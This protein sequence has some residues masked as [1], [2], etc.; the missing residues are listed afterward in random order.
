[1]VPRLPQ[2]GEHIDDH[3]VHFSLKLAELG[4]I[5]LAQTSV[6]VVKHQAVSHPRPGLPT[7]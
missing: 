3:Q 7:G 2:L 5:R 4:R 1:M 6:G